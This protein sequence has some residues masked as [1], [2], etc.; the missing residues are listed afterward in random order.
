MSRFG[1]H[2]LEC[3]GRHL[4]E[5]RHQPPASLVCVTMSRSASVDRVRLRISNVA[6]VGEMFANSMNV[7]VLVIQCR[8]VLS[9]PCRA[10]MLVHLR[11]NETVK[12]QPGSQRVRTPHIS[13]ACQNILPSTHAKCGIVNMPHTLHCAYAHSAHSGTPRLKEQRAF[14]KG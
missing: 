8:A 5:Q 2:G 7:C 10:V 12:Q 1:C 11:S 3:S 13:A 14:S 4:R 6:F 9:N